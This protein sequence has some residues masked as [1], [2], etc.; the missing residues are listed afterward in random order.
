M[1]IKHILG[2]IA[3]LLIIQALFGCS[4]A[5]LAGGK[6]DDEKVVAP[7][8]G[9]GL[10]MMPIAV[11]D[12]MMNG[13][14]AF[15]MLVP[16]GWNYDAKVEWRHE[17]ENLASSNVVLK[18]PGNGDQVQIYP[19]IPYVWNPNALIPLA[20]GSIYIGGYVMAPIQ[21]PAVFIERVVLPAFRPNITNMQVLDKTPLTQVAQTIWKSTYASNANYGVSAASFT[22]RYSL[23]GG[24]FDETF[25]C[26]LNYATDPALPGAVLWRPEWIF[27]TR[28]FAGE[29][30]KNQGLMMAAATSVTVDMKWFAGYMQ[31]HKLWQDGQMAAIRGAG[32]LSRYVS[33]VNASIDKTI[34]DGYRDRQAS[35]DRVFDSFSESIRGVETYADPMNG[36]VQLPA[37]YSNVWVNTSGEYF[38]S[39]QG[40]VD[41]NVGSTL[42]WTALSPAE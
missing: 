26:A 21:D 3:A 18:N 19:F 30:Q 24:T 15:T 11:N 34:I 31:V 22:I 8:D 28:A 16:Q 40:G 41:P 20:P 27:S 38:L 42:S 6:S 12:P 14:K 25:Y 32:E 29:L 33:G 36:N 13:T 5:D 4:T 2:L 1:N 9:T 35:E 7:T 39:N 10:R 23:N 17:F 37:G